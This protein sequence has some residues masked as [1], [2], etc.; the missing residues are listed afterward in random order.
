[1]KIEKKHLFGIIAA[2][3]IIIVALLFLRG[4]NNNL[5]YFVIGI[6]VFIAF[7]PFIISLTLETSR[8]KENNEMFLEFARNLAESVKAGT[9]I[10]R[11]I[12][13]VRTKTYGT[14]TPY[15][16]KLAN[17]IAIGISIKDAM[18]TF[19]SDVD[20]PVVSRAIN[21]IIEAEKAGGEIEKILDSVAKSISDIEKLKKERSAAISGL[22]VQGYIIFLIFVVIMLVLKFKILPMATEFGGMSGGGDMGGMGFGGGEGGAS[23]SAEDLA[24]PLLFLLMTQ[25]FFTGLVIGKLA[26]GRIKPGLKHSFIMVILAFLITKGADVLIA[27]PKAVP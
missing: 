1:M 13:N 2:I 5:A 20:S 24:Y 25:G 16:Q 6:G 10:S 3:I 17:Q 8:E 27:V 26:E 18:T 14:L 12:L 23:F 9:P 4:E 19:A 11:S 21:L 15:V 22:L 7:L